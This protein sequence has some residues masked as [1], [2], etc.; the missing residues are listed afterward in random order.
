M[1][2]EVSGWCFDVIDDLEVGVGVDRFGGGQHLAERVQCP[3]APGRGG[4]VEGDV[5]D[6]GGDV[7]VAGESWLHG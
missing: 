6:A 4:G 1:D 7:D 3:A 5:Q 2:H